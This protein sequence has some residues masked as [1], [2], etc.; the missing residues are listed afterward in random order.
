MLIYEMSEKK[1]GQAMSEEEQEESDGGEDGGNRKGRGGGG[2]GGG[3]DTMSE[4]DP[5]EEDEPEGDQDFE[6]PR[7][8]QQSRFGGGSQ[9]VP[10]ADG[11]SG[12]PQQPLPQP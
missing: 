1:K 6:Q 8:S 10:K 3:Y 9:A 11:S 2:G 7:Q 5:H 12:A 4:R